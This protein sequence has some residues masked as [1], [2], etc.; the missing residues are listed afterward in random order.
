MN[1]RYEI[2]DTYGRKVGYATSSRGQETLFNWMRQNPHRLHLGRIGL[3][4]LK[5]DGSV[6]TS[7]DDLTHVEQTLDLW[8][9]LLQSKFSLGD[10]RLSVL[11]CVHPDL[12]LLAVR[13]E[14]PLLHAGDCA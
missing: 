6:V 8:S 7:S 9:G 11:S 3:E 13:V 4:L 5:P 1:F 12:D 14:S 2:Y 10:S